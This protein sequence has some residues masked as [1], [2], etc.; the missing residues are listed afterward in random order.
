MLKT[1]DYLIFGA[2]IYGCYAFDILSRKYPN[3][4]IIILEH[5]EMPF[6]RASYIN[7][8]RVH[9]G[10]HYPR[11][12]HTALKSA[13]YYNKF[14]QD[15]SFAVNRKFNKIYALSN[16]FSLCNRES[17]IKFCDAANIPHKEIHSEEYFK[18]NMIEASFLTEEFSMDANIIKNYYSNKFQSQT[19]IEVIF[20]A[21]L[22]S[23]EQP[24]NHYRI[25][26]ADGTIIETDYVINTS[27][28]SINQINLRFGFELLQIKYEI[29]EL[30]LCDVPDYLK[31]EGITVMDGVFFSLMPF[32]LSGNHSLSAVHYTP[33]K[34]SI[35]RDR[36]PHFHCQSLNINCNSA[37]LDNCNSCHAQPKTAWHEMLQLTN[38]YLK[39]TNEIKY[40]SSLFAM[41][42]ILQSSEISDSRPTIIETHSTNPYFVSVLSGKFNAIYD[43][44][45]IL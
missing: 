33:H 32:G 36:L 37:Q 8:A 40:K 41:K 7:Q 12:L 43:L 39:Q 26:L 22:A 6:Q 18:P 3:K 13:Q 15:F 5:D 45:E 17:F 4:R 35:T 11:S 2:G 31:Q 29:A 30:I 28:A 19:N 24:A 25:K 23:V 38:K 10:Y 21:S 27:Y 44:E 20:G 42:A 9:N 34:T 14:N 16:Y 1:C